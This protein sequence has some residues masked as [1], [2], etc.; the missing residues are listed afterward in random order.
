MCNEVENKPGI[1]EK[2][3]AMGGRVE[4]LL[5][6]TALPALVYLGVTLGLPALN[7]ASLKY[8]AGFWR[9]AAATCVTL[10]ALVAMLLALELGY[11]WV[12]GRLLP[13]AGRSR[14]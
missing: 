1:A 14:K 8:G 12:F 9:H 2:A 4:V 3:A 13:G 11:D 5:K 7:G 10:A 6:R